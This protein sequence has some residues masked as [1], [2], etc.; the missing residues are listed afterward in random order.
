MM[1]YLFH[2]ESAQNVLVDVGLRVTETTN[3]QKGFKKGLQISL[4]PFSTQ[5][6]KPQSSSR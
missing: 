3:N 5:Q 2:P 1:R 6:L 4:E